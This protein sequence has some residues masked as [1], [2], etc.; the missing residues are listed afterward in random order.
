MMIDVD[1]IFVAPALN[2]FR[3]APVSPAIDA[4]DPAL[5]LPDML[6]DLDGKPRNLGAGVD[7]GAFEA[8]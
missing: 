6:L 2:D 5:L 8:R 4:G 3:L 1:P 7:L